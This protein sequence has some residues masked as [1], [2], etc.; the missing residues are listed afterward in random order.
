MKGRLGADELKLY[1]VIWDRFVACQMSA[2]KIEQRS[3]EIDALPRKG[4]PV[5]RQ[6]LFRASA[7]QVIF[8]GYMKV[9]GVEKQK[10]EDGSEDPE[11]L[12]PLTEGEGLNCLEWLSEEKETQ[13]PGRYS[14]ASLVRALEENGVGRPSTYAQTIATIITRD[15]VEREKRTLFPTELGMKVHAFL[16]ESLSDLFNVSFTASME[17]ALDEVEKGTVEWTSMLGDFYQKFSVWIEAAKGPPVEPDRIVTLIRALDSVTEWAPE[18]KRG[19]RTYGDER[20]VRSLEKQFDDAKKPFSDR[21]LS[22]LAMLAWRY[23]EQAPAVEGALAEVGMS[24]IST[25]P[26]AEPPR[27]TSI[28]KLELLSGMAFDPPPED[29]P[30]AFNEK[31]FVFSL[32]SRTDSG[33]RLST[34]QVRVLN[35]L[36]LKFGNQIPNFAEIKDSLDLDVKDLVEG[37]LL[38]DL[39]EAMGSVK[40]WREPVKRGKREFNDQTFYESLSSQLDQKGALSSRQY[41]ALKRL[42]SKY[43]AQ[44]PGYDGLAAKH[45]IG[46]KKAA[47]SEE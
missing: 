41:A 29:D 9:S 14:E 26:D 24:D 2:A 20:F 15:Y 37:D 45:E 33:R 1:K 46:K 19:K 44:I 11:A 47:K 6:Y 21:Q 10:A 27:D 43:K 13:P 34:A 30:K 22:A 5:T 40:E 42:V 3:V 31:D 12:P 18:T 39:I 7:S 36:V 35:R 38:R 17:E 8:P 4:T 28:R 16:T 32:K 25:S 23:R